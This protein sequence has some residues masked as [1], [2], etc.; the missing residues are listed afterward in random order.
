MSRKLL[1]LALVVF[2]AV[3]GGATAQPATRTTPCGQRAS[4]SPRPHVVWIWMENHTYDEIVGSASAPFANQLIGECGLATK[5]H[6][7]THPSLPNYLAATSGGTQGVADDGDPSRHPLRAAS[8]FERAASAASFEEDMPGRCALAN[9]G[10]YAVRHNPEAYFV[11]ARELCRK[12]DLPLGT[13]AAGPLA[14]A[15]DT[16][17]LPDFSLVTPNLCDDTHDCG[18]AVGDAWLRR[19]VT[20]L[21]GSRLYRQGSLVLFVTWDEG[22]SASNH[23][24]AI[25]VS[26][27]TAP[28]TTSDV[29]YTH[30][31]LLRTTEELLGIPDLLGHA[32]S[33][34]SMR[35]AFQLTR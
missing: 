21:A 24:P 26:P 5:Y 31:S 9:A 34:R 27:A 10:V 32:A 16:S 19:W 18:V 4:L 35:S 29:P 30:Y 33:A 25:V 22:N 1:L 6:A 12:H 2:A 20:R 28:G 11:R 7:I 13:T 15:L 8:I 17:S 23:I 14:H 3:P